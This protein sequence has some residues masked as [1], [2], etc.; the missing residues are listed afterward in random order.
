MELID[1]R[2]SVPRANETSGRK[3]FD[4]HVLGLLPPR[5]LTCSGSYRAV[6]SPVAMARPKKHFALRRKL[7]RAVG[8]RNIGREKK[9]RKMSSSPRQLKVMTHSRQLAPAPLLTPSCRVLRRE[10]S[11][12]RKK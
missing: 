8:A 6:S 12:L 2:V 1:D 3:V 7:G 11:L 5:V 9:H 10:L 4:E